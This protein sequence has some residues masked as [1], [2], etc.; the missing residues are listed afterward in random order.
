MSIETH[1]KRGTGIAYLPL[2][3]GA[4]T[5]E[6]QIAV[7]HPHRNPAKRIA[8]GEE[9]QWNER[10]MSFDAEHKKTRRKRYNACDELV[11]RR[12]FEPRTHCLK[13]SCSAD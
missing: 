11:T 13:G 4:L 7:P 3:N 12:G 1:Q 6:A 10:E 9:E 2:L 8:V 5:F